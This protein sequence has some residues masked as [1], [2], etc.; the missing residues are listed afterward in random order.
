MQS[1][2][3]IFA[4]VAI[5]FGVKPNIYTVKTDV[6]ELATYDCFQGF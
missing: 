3:F 2:L 4:Y 1:H 5:D 6:K